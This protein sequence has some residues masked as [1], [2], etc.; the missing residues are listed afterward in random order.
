MKIMSFLNNNSTLFFSWY[1][2]LLCGAINYINFKGVCHIYSIYILIPIILFLILLFVIFIAFSIFYSF[3]Q[4]IKNININKMYA[5]V[6]LISY[7]VFSWIFVPD[8]LFFGISSETRLFKLY[9]FI[10]I[11]LCILFCLYHKFKK[12]SIFI[13]YYLFFYGVNFYLIFDSLLNSM[14]HDC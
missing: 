2:V 9:I 13:I 14:I 12:Q 5:F 6:L 4:S 11:N 3:Y 10:C 1:C 7:L 8:I